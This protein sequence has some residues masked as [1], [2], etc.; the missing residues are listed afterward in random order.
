MRTVQWLFVVSALLFISGIAFVVA[1]AR[2][3]TAS[4]TP[5]VETPAIKPVASVKQLMRGI[6][7]PAATVVFESVSTTVSAAGIEEKQPKTD[8]EWAELGSSA[9][10]LVEAGNLL[11]M[12]DRAIDRGEWVMMTQALMDAGTEALKAADT[13]SAEGILAAGEHI[14]TSCDNCHQRYWRQ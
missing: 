7:A 1:S 8:E 13:K 10:A 14:N 11:V 2:T 3:H 9:A 5:V 4:P 6:V 12:G